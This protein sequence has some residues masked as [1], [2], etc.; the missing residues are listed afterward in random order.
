[1]GYVVEFAV[2]GLAGHKEIV[3]QKLNRDVNVFFGPNGSGKTSLL[4][5]LHSALDGGD[6]S[7]LKNVP[8]RTAEV[9]IY[10]FAF[11]AVFTRTAQR[12]DA[13][14]PRDQQAT[15]PLGLAVS[16]ELEAQ[17][18]RKAH[19]K[20]VWSTEPAAGKLEIGT[21]RVRNLY[22]PTSRLWPS[23]TELQY[24]ALRRGAGADIGL[25]TDEAL[26]LA[27][28][29]SIERL[30]N[31]YSARILQKV[32]ATQED[33]LAKILREILI[34]EQRRSTR[35]KGPDPET[36]YK[37]VE[38]FLGRQ[39]SKEGF[40][41]KAAFQR[42]YSESTVVQN[43]VG[44]ID[45]VESGIEEAMTPRNKLQ[46]LIRT[47]FSGGKSLTLMDNVIDIRTDEGASISIASLSSG[48]KHALLILLR[49]VY[50]ERDPI[51]IDE[52]EISMHVDW[53]KDLIPSLQSVAKDAQL[54]VAT[55]SPEIMAPIDDSKIFRL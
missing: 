48:E 51:L 46:A 55:H 47:M 49:A 1:M 12:L 6:A 36:A 4:K 40:G 5:I 14:E 18:I 34:G 45:E 30:W 7:T 43:V 3:A 33:G 28:Q 41:S 26:D 19:P 21:Y 25:G 52:P 44:L 38:R 50:M 54:I 9:K 24:Y 32:R 27:F 37:R 31:A 23:S 8:F 22:L 10:S 29:T 35:Q 20:I 39:K 17:R 53:Q 13:E 11:D 2:E 42:R 15:L 16:K